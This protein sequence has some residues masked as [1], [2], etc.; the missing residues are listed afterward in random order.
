ML[1]SSRST[2]FE[3]HRNW[4]AIT[5]SLPL[6]RWYYEKTS[7]WT[8]DY[9]PLFAYFEWALSQV[10][11]SFDPRM[12]DVK[13]LNYASDQTILFQRFS[14][15]VMDVIYALGVRRCLGA[16]TAGGHANSSRSQ[17]IGGALL[18]GN[19]GLL[20]V[21]HIHFQYNGFLFGVLLLS[22]GALLEGRPLQSAALFAVLL[23]LK[24]IFI[25]VA[26]VYVVYL[27]RFYCLR[28]STPLQALIKLIKLGTVVL[29]VCLLSF[30]PFYAHLPQVGPSSV[31]F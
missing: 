18:L 4:L 17:L 1:Y 29:A 13:N 9:P 5:H 25:Y 7:E 8:L 3:V 30:G 28:G 2:D 26:P 27:L 15:I 6:S 11:K 19:A 10:A 21:D 31:V 16:L 20:M 23:N 22:I 24:H 12:L 14:V